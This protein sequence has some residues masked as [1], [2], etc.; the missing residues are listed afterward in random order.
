MSRVKQGA[1]ERALGLLAQREHSTG[2]LKR[3]LR[4]RGYQDAEI[5]DALEGLSEAALQSDARYVEQMLRSAESRGWGPLLIA[6]KLRQAGLAQ[7]AV[8]AALSAS[9]IDWTQAALACLSRRFGTDPAPDHKEYARRARFLAA[10]GYDSE[11]IHR[12]LKHSPEL[13]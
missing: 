6:E 5:G 11:S 1:R 7:S 4:Q 9:G 3:K 8:R 10:R 2:E 12:A 13:P